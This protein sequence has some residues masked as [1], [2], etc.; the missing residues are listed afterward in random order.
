[1]CPGNE[2]VLRARFQDALFFYRADLKQQLQD[3]KPALA[4]IAFQ[5]DLGSMLDKTERVQA[6]VQA[7]GGLADLPAGGH[8]ALGGSCP[9]S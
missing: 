6:L 7:L 1:M 8:F 5:K 4:N 3:F 2:A 9:S